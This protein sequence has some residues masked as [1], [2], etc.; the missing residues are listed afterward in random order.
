MVDDDT[1]DQ[2]TLDPDGE[3]PAVSPAS[4]EGLARGTD[5]GRFMILD[6]V[7]AGGMG[8]VYSAW[9]AALDRKVALKVLRPCG[10]PEIEARRQS[11]LQREARIVARLSHANIVTV[12]DLGVY[13]GQVYMAMEFV[14]GATLRA[15]LAAQPRPPSEVLR[16]LREAGR[17]L[18]AAHA[19]GL[20]HRD[21]KPDN[22]LIGLDGRIKV[23]DFGTAASTGAGDDRLEVEAAPLDEQHSTL[24]ASGG[25]LGTPPYMAPEQHRGEAVD[26]RADQFAFCVVLYEALCG[27]RPFAGDDIE[28]LARAIAG[29]VV[30]PPPATA[31]LPGHVHRALLRGLRPAV[32]ERF[33]SMTELLAAL[34]PRPG[35]GRIAVL[36][37]ATAAL[38]VALGLQV[39]LHG[40]AWQPCRDAEAHIA[41]VWNPTR[42]AQLIEAFAATGRYHAAETSRRVVQRLDDYAAAWTRQW[43]LACEAT[44]VSGEQ[45]EAL[46]DLRMQCLRRR[47]DEMRALIA[48]LTEQTDAALVDEAVSACGRLAEVESCA[49]TENLLSTTPLPG[50]PALRDRIDRLEGALDEAEALERAGRYPQALEAVRALKDEVRAVGHPPL[51]GRLLL[52]EGALLWQVQDRPAATAALQ[53]ADLVAAR[54]RDDLLRA[55]AM[56]VLLAVRGGVDPQAGLALRAHAEAA[57]ERAGNS[58]RQRARLDEVVGGLLDDAGAYDEARTLLVRAVERARQDPEPGRPDLSSPLNRLA[59]VLKHLGEEDHALELYQQALALDEAT[60]G[61]SHPGLVPALNN[62]ATLLTEQGQYVE[63]ERALRRGL[64]IREQALGPAHPDVATSLSKLGLVLTRRGALDEAWQAHQRALT[65]RA[66]ALGAT[67]PQV[68]FSLDAMGFVREQ[69]G[70]YVE[71]R[72]HYTRALEVLQQAYGET[73]PVVGMALSNLGNVALREKHFAEARDRQ[74]R[75]LELISAREPATSVRRAHPLLGLGEAELGLG[76][77]ER[78]LPLLEQAL[79]LF[80]DSAAGPYPLGM[81]RFALARTLHARG[82]RRRADAL[83]ARAEADLEQSAVEGAPDLA[84]LRAWSAARDTL[85]R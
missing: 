53:E 21:F 31:R 79:K 52:R 59:V 47:Q 20:V 19:A 32:E 41:E 54:A 23:S 35:R 12:H 28:S 82:E 39:W 1:L 36:A 45:S 25:R 71:A 9:D 55:Q 40:E 14:E 16:V 83:L 8:V 17:G 51:L 61:P 60:L 24:T 75:A 27:V 66:Q 80:E 15:W 5:L 11:R 34:D 26:A 46:L 63:A 4:I 33:A 43:T 74:R 37:L 3:S 70:R 68:G 58:D 67:S 50:D 7:G 77:P 81:T 10:D 13:R 48:L 2:A 18:V 44:H 65:I 69:Q 56:T 64:E 62:I 84:R 73:H 6:R 78:A 30:R 38:A 85:S 22:V 57:V 42:S 72:E 29:G 76:H 49:A